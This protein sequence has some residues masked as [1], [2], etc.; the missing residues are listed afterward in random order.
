[1]CR[2]F[3]ATKLWTTFVLANKQIKLL[4]G[5]Y[6]LTNATGNWCLLSF[7][8]EVAFIHWKHFKD[9][10]AARWMQTLTQCWLVVHFWASLTFI[11]LLDKGIVPFCCSRFFSSWL[12]LDL[13]KLMLFF[14]QLSGYKITSKTLSIH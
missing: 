10:S 1:M 4:N 3:L 9:Y 6:V 14:G 8:S 7:A 12:S 13:P 11:A 5:G 2:L